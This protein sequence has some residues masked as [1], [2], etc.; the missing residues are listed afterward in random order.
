MVGTVDETASDSYLSAI[1]ETLP[2]YREQ[3]IVHPGA[4]LR[5]VNALLVRNVRLGPWI[6]T[7]SRCRMLDVARLPTT[8]GAHAVV[9]ETFERNG[10]DYVR[11]DALVLSDDKPVMYVDH[12]AIYKVAPAGS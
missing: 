9:T 8:L 12:T 4:L 10:H 6:H 1:A 5:M 11:Y 2:L 7:A 3:A